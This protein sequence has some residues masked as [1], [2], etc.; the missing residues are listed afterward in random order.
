MQSQY[1]KNMQLIL[2]ASQ[3]SEEAKED[4]QPLPD[5]QNQEEV[6][7][8]YPVDIG[9]VQGVLYTKQEVSPAYFTESTVTHNQE[10]LAPQPEAQPQKEASYFAHFFLI[11][12]FFLLLDNVS[13]SIPVF[14]TP[15]A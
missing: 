8:A 9:G 1:A 3:E 6:L 10:D 15:T 13:N 14:L 5:E 11:L 12:C 4:T 2:A 7:H